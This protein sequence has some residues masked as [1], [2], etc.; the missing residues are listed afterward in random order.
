VSF[1]R[2]T[3]GLGPDA[4]RHWSGAA[5]VRGALVC[6]PAVAVG[7][8]SGT[9]V[10][11]LLGILALGVFGVV[12]LSRTG[13]GRVFNGRSI[14]PLTMLVP[15]FFVCGCLNLLLLD[16]HDSKGYYLTALAL[17]DATGG[18][19]V[20][21]Q[22][23]TGKEGYA[24][25]LSYFVR[26]GVPSM[27]IPVAVNAGLLAISAVIV[28]RSTERL[29]GWKAARLVPAI[30][31]LSPTIVLWGAPGLREASI[32]LG[33]SVLIWMAAKTTT[34]RRLTVLPVLALAATVAY[35]LLLRATI[36]PV[37][38]A[39][40]V[41][42]LAVAIRGPKRLTL[43]LSAVPL[44][45]LFFRLVYAVNVNVIT[46]SYDAERI[47]HVRASLAGAGSSFGAFELT[48]LG[49][50]AGVLRVF[51]G[52]F[53]WEWSQFPLAIADSIYWA[54]V[55]VL[56]VWALV[57]L[58]RDRVLVLLVPALALAMSVVVTI[59]NYGTLIRLR[60]MVLIFLI[61]IVAAGLERVTER[62]RLRR[63]PDQAEVCP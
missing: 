12:I 40:L 6:V 5:A 1:S 28:T 45:F 35:L 53:P 2:V 20:E 34:D 15:W 32:Y 42:G 7:S 30:F 44:G 47:G 63:S 33:L 61:P 23:D 16:Q 10:A 17:A 43:V 41:L 25:L 54:G 24:L 48:P 4:P 8:L 22:T 49:V 51:A 56:V 46:S 58:T 18:G 55:S 36:V 14:W 39:G 21:V 37:T 26:L 3:L 50:L 62:R 52:P 19:G 57:H 27:A 11:P 9:R 13:F 59:T 38:V 60:G 29:F 31:A